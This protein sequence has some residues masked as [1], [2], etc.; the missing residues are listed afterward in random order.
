MTGIRPIGVVHLRRL[1]PWRDGR[2]Y[3]YQQFLFAIY[4]AEADRPRPNAIVASPSERFL[5]VAF[6]PYDKVRA[7]DLSW[8]PRLHQRLFLEAAVRALDRSRHGT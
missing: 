2:P 4:A 8:P 3:P 1:G 6:L 7:L 5:S